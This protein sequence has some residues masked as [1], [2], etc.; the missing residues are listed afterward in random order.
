MSD[1][2]RIL[3]STP[4]QPIHPLRPTRESGR[5]P[6]RPRPEKPPRPRRE[7]DRE[8]SERTPEAEG[9]AP[10]AEDRA[11]PHDADHDADESDAGDENP[12]RLPHID[13]RV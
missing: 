3:P 1:V 6:R 4:V 12:S 9:P 2:P 11:T 5:E 7:S 8:E 10:D 13:L